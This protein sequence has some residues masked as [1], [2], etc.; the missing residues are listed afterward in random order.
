VSPFAFKFNDPKID[1]KNAV[2]YIPP[3]KRSEI[4]KYLSSSHIKFPKGKHQI[5]STNHHDYKMYESIDE[6]T[7]FRFKNE[8]KAIK[9]GHD[10]KMDKDYKQEKLKWSMIISKYDL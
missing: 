10:S 6:L 1:K 7:A 8:K 9:F 5:K 2:N 4:K 3:K